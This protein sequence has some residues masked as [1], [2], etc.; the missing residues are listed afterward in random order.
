MVAPT[1]QDRTQTDMFVV[2]ARLAVVFARFQEG[3]L[4]I[5]YLH[6]LIGFFTLR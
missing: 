2:V 3:F 4:D 5:L 1:A 6:A